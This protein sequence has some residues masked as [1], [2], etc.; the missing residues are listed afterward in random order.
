[1]FFFP[2]LSFSL[3]L[4]SSLFFSSPSFFKNMQKSTLESL[5][6][7]W[8]KRGT[9]RVGRKEEE[10]K[11]SEVFFFEIRRITILLYILQGHNVGL[12]YLFLITVNG[13]LSS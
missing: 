5:L 2:F 11:K 3:L 4:F 12:I 13:E 10:R 8:H 9:E 7:S 1:M 6:P